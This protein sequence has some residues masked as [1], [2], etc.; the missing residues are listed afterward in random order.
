MSDKALT[1]TT[2]VDWTVLLNEGETTEEDN[3]S[4]TSDNE[5]ETRGTGQDVTTLV[6]SGFSEATQ[7]DK[8]ADK[9]DKSKAGETVPLKGTLDEHTDE[10]IDDT[11]VAGIVLQGTNGDGSATTADTSLFGNTPSSASSEPAQK[12]SVEFED[13]YN[14]P[15][16][17]ISDRSAV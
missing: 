11:S 13:E 8:G 10:N 16:L 15:L 5:A 12:F 17:D 3:L 6:V 7:T 2:A 4:I 1:S 14:P 9:S